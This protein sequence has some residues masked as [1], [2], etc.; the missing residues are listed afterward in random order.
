MESLHHKPVKR[1][2]LEG[3]IYDDAAIPRLKSEY[4]KLL[5]LEMKLSGYA[6]RLDI[7]PDFTIQYNS[8]KEIF[9]FKLSLYAIYVGKRK[10]EWIAGVDGTTV[11][12][13]P[14]SRSKE[15]SQEVA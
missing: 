1:F 12:Y 15:F 13:T 7:N 4:V 10:S 9:Q 2:Y 3:D 14:Q 5:M 11:I 6:I 8:T